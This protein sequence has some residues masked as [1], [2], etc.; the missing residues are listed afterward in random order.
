MNEKQVTKSR[1]SFYTSGAPRQPKEPTWKYHW[2]RLFTIKTLESL[3]SDQEHSKLKKALT[4]FDLTMIGI[5]N[6]IGAGIF[7]LTGVTAATNAGP[8]IVISFIISGIAAAFAALSYSELASMIPVSGSAY[9]YTYATM[10]EVM[11]WIIGWDLIL[12]YLVGAATVAVGWSKYFV[13]LFSDAF[14]VDFSE[15]WTKSP[16]SFNTDTQSFERVPDAYFNLPAFIISII[17]T[18][19]LIFGIK[20]SARVN[21]I[22]VSVKIFIIVLF[23][24]A[25]STKIDPDNYKPFVPKNE[26]SF[27]KFGVSGIFSAASIVFFSYIG[28]DSVSTTSQE[29]RNP[30]RDLPIGI[31]GSLGIS[32]VLY[33]AVCLVL[34][35]IVPY[36]KL[37]DP[38]PIGLAVRDVGLRW[39]EIIVDIG[40]LAGLSSVILTSLMGQPRIFYSMASDGLFPKFAAKIHPK[41]RTPYITTALTG[42]IC[43]I[44]SAILPIDV[45]AE[46]T[47]VGTL[48]AFFLVNIG[49][50]ILRKTAPDAPRKFKAPGGP[51]FVPITGALLSLL[52]LVTATKASIERLFI[53]MAIGLIIYAFYGR[54]HSKVNNPS[55]IE[56]I[57]GSQEKAIDSSNVNIEEVKVTDTNVEIIEKDIES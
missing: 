7:V 53:W 51:Y 36:T 49:V 4:A 9:T 17:V 24:L 21:A 30:Q 23:V 8:A 40:A 48:L 12:E 10:G 47:S 25:A 55:V 41:Y 13:I 43:A 5:G 44:A 11:A 2:R 33:I 15:S 26:G 45:L 1:Y 46:L 35:G 56:T 57:D 50:L 18:F 37:D 42:T 22:I 38:A 14:H 27:S 31:I 34:T 32:T 29:V 54:T 20:E 3:E 16:F 6:V 52:L 39:L 28:F 19:L